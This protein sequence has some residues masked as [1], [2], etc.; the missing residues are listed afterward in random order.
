MRTVLAITVFAVCALTA[1]AQEP[2]VYESKEGKFVAKFP[3]QPGTIVSTAKVK[4]AGQ[5]VAL[6]TSDKGALAFTVGYADLTAEALKDSPAPKVLEKSEQGLTAQTKVKV[7]T[8]KPTVYKT[9]GKEY[10]AR[11]VVCERDGLQMR[12]LLVLAET[13]LYQVFVI[14][15]K[16]AIASKEADAFFASFEIRN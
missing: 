8:A 3:T 5:E 2:A 7:L 4:A 12:F 13:R 6:C 10:P 16:D 15:A 14:G 11:E 9:G 1:G